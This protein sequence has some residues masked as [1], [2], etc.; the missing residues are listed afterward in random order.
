MLSEEKIIKKPFIIQINLEI[1]DKS[2]HHSFML[3]QLL[4]ILNITARNLNPGHLQTYQKPYL[5][6]LHQIRTHL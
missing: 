3:A 2:T 6:S 1:E 4:S 5:N